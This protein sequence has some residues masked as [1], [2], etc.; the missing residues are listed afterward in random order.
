MRQAVLFY[1]VICFYDK[2][3]FG[4]HCVSGTVFEVLR[5]AMRRH[6]KHPS[7]RRAHGRR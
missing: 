3:L 7:P 2:Y 1:P 6:I 4:T 5:G